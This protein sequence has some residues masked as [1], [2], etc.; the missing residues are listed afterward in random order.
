MGGWLGLECP[1]LR[2]GGT[3][4]STDRLDSCMRAGKCQWWAGFGWV[5]R[6]ELGTGSRG[7]EAGTTL[8]VAEQ[9]QSSSLEAPQASAPSIPPRG[10][11]FHQSG[12]SQPRSGP[13]SRVLNKC[14]F[15]N[16]R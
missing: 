4:G 1:I 3:M 15:S 14:F 6:V 9:D 8:E 10:L 5:L 12:P 13:C 16:R 7:S 11:L 2:A